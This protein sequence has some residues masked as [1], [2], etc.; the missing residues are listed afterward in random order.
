M[1]AKS[2][3]IYDSGAVAVGAV[4]TSPLLDVSIF[5]NVSAYAVQSAGAAPREL[6]CDLYANGLLIGRGEYATIP[7]PGNG[8][9]CLNNGENSIA[10][11]AVGIVPNVLS[12]IVFSVPAVADPTSNV[13]VIVMGRP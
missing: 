4:I 8:G 13:R 5:R 1:S 9:A 2:R 12:G 10:F 7:V 11:G 3:V 6:R